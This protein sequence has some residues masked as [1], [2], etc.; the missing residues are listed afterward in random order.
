MRLNLLLSGFIQVKQPNV[1]RIYSAGDRSGPR[2]SDGALALDVLSASVSSA[3]MEIIVNPI[4][5]P[6]LARTL[7]SG[8]LTEGGI[9]APLNTVTVTHLN[10]NGLPV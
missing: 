7:Q 2:F 9:V 1:D 8:R 10:H 6:T 5:P 3:V 4:N